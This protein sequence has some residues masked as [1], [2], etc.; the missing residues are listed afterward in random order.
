RCRGSHLVEDHLAG[1]VGAY[2][3]ERR[4]A[5]RAVSGRRLDALH[6]GPRPTSGRVQGCH[7]Q[8]GPGRGRGARRSDPAVPEE[9][10]ELAVVRCSTNHLLPPEPPHTHTNQLTTTNNNSC[11]CAGSLLWAG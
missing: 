6:V 11:C 9:P 1:R 7:G 5:V 3:L 2:P 4:L 10:E 8:A